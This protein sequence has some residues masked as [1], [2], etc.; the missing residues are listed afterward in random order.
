VGSSR[1]ENLLSASDVGL[2]GLVSNGFED[3]L[4]LMFDAATCRLD[5]AEVE[6]TDETTGEILLVGTLD[7]LFADVTAG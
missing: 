4:E 2:L 7:P 5:R 1:S 3:R 6:A